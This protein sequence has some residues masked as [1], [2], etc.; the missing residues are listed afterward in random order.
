M[1][2]IRVWFML[3]LLVALEKAYILWKK[4]QKHY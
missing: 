2:H 4:T 1:E 3:M